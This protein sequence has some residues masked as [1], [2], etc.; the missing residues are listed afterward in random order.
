MNTC[1]DRIVYSLLIDALAAPPEAD[2]FIAELCRDGA[3]ARETFPVPCPDAVV[4]GT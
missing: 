2:E 4:D 3:V 1:L